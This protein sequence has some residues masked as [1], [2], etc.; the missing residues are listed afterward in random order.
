[1]LLGNDW[2]LNPEVRAW[3]WG[4]GNGAIEVEIKNNQVTWGGLNSQD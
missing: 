1:M 2:L 4:E 3:A